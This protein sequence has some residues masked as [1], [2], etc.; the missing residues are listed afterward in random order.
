MKLLLAIFFAG[1]VG[2]TSH[3]ATVAKVAHV[4]LSGSSIETGKPETDPETIS[5]AV[6]YL[7]ASAVSLWIGI[8]TS[9][10]LS[11]V[12]IGQAIEGALPPNTSSKWRIKVLMEA[13]ELLLPK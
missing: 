10:A 3:R 5:L 4:A 2:C 6:G 9:E 8:P 11:N 1:L 12:A 7:D 13:E